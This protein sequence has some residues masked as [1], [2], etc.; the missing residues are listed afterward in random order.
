MIEEHI[1]EEE[2]K[3]KQNTEGILDWEKLKAKIAKRIVEES[4]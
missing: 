3:E 4:K 1:T 2:K